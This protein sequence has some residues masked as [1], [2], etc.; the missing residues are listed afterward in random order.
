M[1][2]RDVISAGGSFPPTHW[3]AVVAAGRDSASGFSALE[4]L[5]RSY[6]YPLYAY[7][8]RQGHNPTDAQDLT[9]AFFAR[10]LA[11]HGFSRVQPGRGRFRS[12][13]LASL[14]NFLINEWD[15]ARTQKRGEG[16][17]PLPLDD[18]TMEPRYSEDLDPSLSAERLYERVWG[19]TVIAEAR[20]QVQADFEAAG[21]PQRFDLLEPLMPG[22]ESP[23]GIE[24]VAARLGLSTG[25]VRSEVHRLKKRLRKAL[26]AEVAKTVEKPE[27]VDE[28]IR[29]LIAAV[30][31]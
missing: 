29:H 5:C 4:E 30:S 3:S 13:L 25:S 27:E 16:E 26:R 24:E 18:S 20:A 6:W 1:G 9:Q 19:L 17:I 11:N 21:N 15:R 28:E 7:V 10:F 31:S 8:R 2:E 23:L 12:F 22:E 14:Q